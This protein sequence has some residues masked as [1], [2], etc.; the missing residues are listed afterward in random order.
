MPGMRKYYLVT[1][2]IACSFLSGNVSATSSIPDVGCSGEE[3]LVSE[4]WSSFDL[5]PSAV[6]PANSW[7]LP[8]SPSSPGNM[9]S[10]HMTLQIARDS[11]NDDWEARFLI[12]FAAQEQVG[13][14]FTFQQIVLDWVDSSGA[15]SEVLDWSRGCS[16]VGSSIVPGQHL[17]FSFRLNKTKDSTQITS[18]HLRLWGSRN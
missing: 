12:Q 17:S 8:T 14:P 4:Q 15:R 13:I 7:T 2:V 11:K 9:T 6:I 18:P 5:G 10:A 3:P 16:G 1:F